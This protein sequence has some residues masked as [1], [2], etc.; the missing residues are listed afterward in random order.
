MR[1]Q[2]APPSGA[3]AQRGSG[4][5]TTSLTRM[6]SYSSTAAPAQPT[7]STENWWGGGHMV[8]ARHKRGGVSMVPARRR[9]NAATAAQHSTVA[10]RRPSINHAHLQD[11]C[12]QVW[13]DAE[14]R[15]ASHQVRAGPAQPQR[16]ALAA[17]ET[18]DARRHRG[19]GKHGAGGQAVQPQA[20]ALEDKLNGKEGSGGWRV[21]R[22]RHAC[23]V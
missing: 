4:R 15:D 6:P 12:Q 11:V 14:V 17:Q 23:V 21:K 5:S 2:R 18:H 13:V 1:P 22:G 20:A 9:R 19:G 7:P 3:L 10:I 16:L 8:A